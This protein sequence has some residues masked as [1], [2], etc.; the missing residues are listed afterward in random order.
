MAHL[1]RIAEL[2]AEIADLRVSLIAF[3]ELEAEIADLRVS[4][5]AFAA[6][7][8]VMWARDNGLPPGH[9]FA[10]HYDLLAKAGARMTDFTRG[11]DQWPT[12]N[13]SPASSAS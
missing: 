13:T 8:M 6:P 7:S 9:L 1:D 11:D 12:V 2:E 4:L 5:I 10:P 3:A